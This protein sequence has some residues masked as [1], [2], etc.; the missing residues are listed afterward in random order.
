[1]VVPHSPCKEGEKMF[2]TQ[3]CF[4]LRSMTAAILPTGHCCVIPQARHSQARLAASKQGNSRA[5]KKVAVAAG[6]ASVKKLE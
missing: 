3:R 1:M 6:G 2:R 4:N 5:A